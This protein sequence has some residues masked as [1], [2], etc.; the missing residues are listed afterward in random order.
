MSIRAVHVSAGNVSAPESAGLWQR[1]GR[2]PLPRIDDLK[3]GL[4]D[5]PEP[6]RAPGPQQ[7]VEA[8]GATSYALTA[9]NRETLLVATALEG[10]RNDTLNKAAFSLAQLVA[11]G[12]LPAAL[13]VAELSA[14]ARQAGL[15]DA[16]IMQ[17]LG[18]ALPAGAAL[19]R[20][21]PP[22]PVLD[23]IEGLKP[24]SNVGPKPTTPPA[25]VTTA[26]ETAPPEGG[27]P[28]PYEQAF[29]RDVALEAHRERVKDAARRMLKAEQDQG[30]AKPRM[31]GLVDFLNEPDEDVEYRVDEVWPTGGRIIFAAQYKSGKS[32]AVGNV[33]RALADGMPLFDRFGTNPA[34]R[35][36]L[37][38]NELDERTMRRWL[39]DQGIRHPEAVQLVPLRGK[40]GA[41]DILDEHVRD[42][43]AAALTGADVVILDCLRPVLDALGL[44]EDKDAGR[45]LVAFDAMLDGAGV[46]EALIV[47]HM[48]HSG[49][50]S[51]GDSRI[52]DWPTATWRIIRQD[53]DDTS[54]PRYFSAFG[55]DVEVPE[56]RI[57]YDPTNRHLILFEGEGRRATKA[58]DLLERV[59]EFLET[60]TVPV[61]GNFVEKNVRGAG[62]AIRAA[63]T[64]G[65]E[66]G[67]CVK[68]FSGWS[69][70]RYDD[71]PQP[72]PEPVPE[73]PAQ[74]RL[75]KGDDGD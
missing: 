32:T 43:W 58:E 19:P 53:S 9:L 28:T 49:E 42:Q 56:S 12:E 18:S 15:D 36:V 54:S 16:E 40:V 74:L 55:R 67:K 68:G 63:L 38:D 62:A 52:L 5:G 39:R 6:A 75:I 50:R 47:H 8:A 27:G 23:W 73:K 48:G 71:D 41:F 46:G 3:N 30:R 17:T 69:V 10:T 37:I 31:V 61:S 60:Q 57:E 22:L 21:A 20:V 24:S 70:V 59:I 65:A 34:H 4:R 64:Q 25:Q 66:A 44:S 13:A 1:S 11:G 33:I 72:D 2:R 7:L 51:R 14:A 26:P 29:N 45:F 35:I